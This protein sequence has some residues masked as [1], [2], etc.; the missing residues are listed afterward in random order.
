LHLCSQQLPGC[1]SRNPFLFKLLHRCPGVAPH[2]QF[3]R[4]F[5]SS[6]Q[7]HALFYLSNLFS[8]TPAPFAQHRTLLISLASMPPHSFY[9]EH[10]LGDRA[11]EGER[12]SPASP[13]QN[14]TKIMKRFR[15]SLHYFPVKSR[16][17]RDSLPWGSTPIPL[18]PQQAHP[19]LP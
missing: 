7:P 4:T 10:K 3:P 12:V 17:A 5:P 15:R 14:K 6:P 19:N 11:T 18:C 1:S 13:S 8:I 9:P 2:S 16:N